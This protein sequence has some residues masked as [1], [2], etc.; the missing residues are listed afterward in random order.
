MVYDVTR[1]PDTATFRRGQPL[2]RPTRPCGMTG[3]HRS[4]V[5][6]SGDA[7]GHVKRKG[8]DVGKALRTRHDTRDSMRWNASQRERGSLLATVLRRGN[9]VEEHDPVSGQGARSIH[10]H[11]SGFG[12]TNLDEED[13]MVN[14]TVLLLSVGHLVTDINQGALPALLPF[15]I[16]E[17]HLSYAA[18]GFLIFACNIAST[19]VQPLFGHLADR[20]ASPWLLP[21]GI[22]CAGRGTGGDRSGTWLWLDS[23]RRHAERDRRRRVSPSRGTARSLSLRGPQGH[24]HEYLRSGRHARLRDWS[25]PGDRRTP[26]LGPGGHGHSRR[27]DHLAGRADRLAP[28]HDARRHKRSDARSLGRSLHGGTRRLGSIRVSHRRSR[29]PGGA[30]LWP[31]HLHPALLDPRPGS[32]QGRGRDGPHRVRPR[33]RGRQSPGRATDRPVRPDPGRGGRLLR[34]SALHARHSWR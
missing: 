17:Y 21:A 13:V 22:V 24:G 16:S 6:I 3:K 30:V 15:L 20:Y 8:R 4:G 2:A 18:A 29:R 7:G 23:P 26:A 14:R 32:I 27:S 9:V 11:P 1:K 5:R 33:R 10:G 34:P 19:V 31:E 25:G 12:Q 28:V